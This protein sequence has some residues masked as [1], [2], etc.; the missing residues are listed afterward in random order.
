MHKAQHST[1]Y[2]L[3]IIF[4]IITRES[5]L[6]SLAVYLPCGLTL[7]WGG[8]MTHLVSELGRRSWAGIALPLF[9]PSP[10][11]SAAYRKGEVL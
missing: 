10:W 4:I 7:L 11:K 6:P 2:K 9:P 8:G 3:A 1:Q 5:L